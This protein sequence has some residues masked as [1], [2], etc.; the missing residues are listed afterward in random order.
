M[1]SKIRILTAALVA[2]AALMGLQAGSASAVPLFHSEVAHT[3]GSG[4]QVGSMVF[5]VNAGTIKCNKITGTGT[6]SSATVTEVTSVPTFSEC[7]AFGFVNVTIDTNGCENIITADFEVHL[8]CPAG[9]NIEVTAFNCT[10]AFSPQSA[11]TVEYTT[12]GSG[13]TREIVAKEEGTGIHYVQTSKSFPGCT[14]GT[15]TNGTAKGEVRTKGTN[16][17]GKQ[18]GIWWTDF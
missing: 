12:T 8:T 4:S 2:V 5:T 11:T 18:V 16:T 6:M 9:K 15:F 7:S 17:E 14:N 13:S 3:L 10:V 1:K